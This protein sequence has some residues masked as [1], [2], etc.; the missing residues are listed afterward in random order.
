MEEINIS[1]IYK[2]N[3]K[4]T[5]KSLKKT[6]EVGPTS[7]TLILINIKFTP[8]INASVTRHSQLN[9]SGLNRGFI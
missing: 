2:E 4:K 7:S 9:K 6:F 5:N 8:Q 1:D 3:K